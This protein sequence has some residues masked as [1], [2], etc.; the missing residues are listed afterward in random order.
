MTTRN[1]LIARTGRFNKFGDELIAHEGYSERGEP[2]FYISA[3]TP[4]SPD[5]DDDHTPGYFRSPKTFFH[6]AEHALE[7]LKSTYYSEFK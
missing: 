1:A 4:L 2:G 7:D 3:E 5:D 6:V